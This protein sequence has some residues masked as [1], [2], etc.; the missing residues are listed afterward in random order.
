MQGK[1]TTQ[2]V[3]ITYSQN[4]RAYNKAQ[5]EEI[6]LFDGLLR[7]L[8]EEVEEPEQHMGRPRTR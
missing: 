7:D 5:T 4:W 8:V 3:R 2:A 1:Q 6:I